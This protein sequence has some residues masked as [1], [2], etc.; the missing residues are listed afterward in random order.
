MANTTTIQSNHGTIIYRTVLHTITRP[1]VNNQSIAR[2]TTAFHYVYSNEFVLDV[3]DA[4]RDNEAIHA[5]AVINQR[6]QVQGILVRRD[7]FATMSRPYAQDLF[8]HRPVAEVTVPARTFQSDQNLFTVS[9]EIDQDMR[10]PGV[11]YYLLVTAAGHFRGIFSS[12]DML[13]YLSQM[14]QNDIALA[15]NLQSR[16]VRERRFVTGPRFEFV[17]ASWTAKGVGGDFYEIRRYADHRWIIAMCDVSGK[18]VAASIITSVIW[19]MM[20]IYDFTSGLA[21]FIRHLNEYLVK[22]FETEK[23]V[24]AVF[25]DYDERSGA[26]ELC[27]MGHS[28]IFL[29]RNSRFMKLNTNQN[30]LPVG[31]VPELEP[32]VDHFV[33]KR[34]D[35]LLLLTDGLTEQENIAGDTYGLDNVVRVFGANKS[36][37]VEN[38]SD[39]LRDDFRQFRGRRNLADDVTYAIMRFADQEVVL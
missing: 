24:T 16:I 22:T 27:D 34:D 39:F 18:G 31:I 30:N 26:L 6:K 11:H 29:F 19:G 32:I 13:V 14:T 21:P 33:P 3:L 9:E 28:H 17:A 25:M 38:I 7:F 23:Y 10:N 35:I 20:S 36:E 12:Q 5:V 37:P 2:I 1:Q 15:R 4:L 8:R